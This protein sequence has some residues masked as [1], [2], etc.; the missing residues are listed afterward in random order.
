MT[1]LDDAITA[2]YKAH[3]EIFAGNF[4]QSTQYGHIYMT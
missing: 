2:F 4:H 1:T 3:N